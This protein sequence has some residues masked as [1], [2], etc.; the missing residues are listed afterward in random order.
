MQRTFFI[1]FD[2]TIC[3]NKGSKEEYPPPTQECVEAIQALRNAKHRIII[4][5]VRGNANETNKPGGLAEMLEY[6]MKYQIPYDG[7]D[8]NKPHF[9]M[10]IDDKGCGVP[11]DGTRNVDWQRVTKTLKKK[12]YL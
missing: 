5:S 1:D 10:M 4:Y 6:L 3:P 2:G 9:T 7:F 8:T 11:L 12:K